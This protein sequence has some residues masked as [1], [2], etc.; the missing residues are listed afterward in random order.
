MNAQEAE[1]LLD[2]ARVAGA[3]LR[4]LDA[5]RWREELAERYTDLAAAFEWFLDHGRGDDALV[6]SLS[7]VEYQRIS[8]LV[9]EGR[10][11]LGRAVRAASDQP[12]RANGLYEAGMLTFWLGENAE[13]N[14][15]FRAS[16]ELAEAVGAHRVVALALCGRARPA[17]RT[18]LDLARDLCEQALDVLRDHDDL[19]ARA[20]ALHVL[21][22]AA[23]M[24]GD[25]DEARGL[26]RRRIDL[27][28]QLGHDALVASEAA[29]L[30]AVERQLGN[31]DSAEELAQEALR[32]SQARKD[33]WIMPYVYNALAAIAVDRGEHAAAA[34]LLGRASALVEAQGNAWPPDEIVHYERS[35][36]AVTAALPA[37]EL[38]QAWAAGVS[39]ARR[40]TA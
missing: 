33:A 10:D 5:P 17:L 26:M 31:L 38:A 28:R 4:G 9:S 21:G 30:S 15:L 39:A 37:D 32:I 12:L 24:R 8:D 18:D 3:G 11:W 25:L 2:L 22:V 1:D 23:Q 35:R 6:L 20:N 13:A 19:Q 29:N 27:A 14:E 7:L 40:S 34:T 36:A 16:Q